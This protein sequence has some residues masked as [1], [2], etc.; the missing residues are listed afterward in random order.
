MGRRALAIACAV[1]AGVFFY[2]ADS[3][4]DG[5]PSEAAPP[6]PDS[7]TPDAGGSGPGGGNDGP[8][9]GV[10]NPDGGT[11]GSGGESDG[12]TGGPDG[13]TSGPDGGTG[14][15]TLPDPN[16]TAADASPG[17]WDFVGSERGGPSRVYGA[18]VDA[19]GNLWVAGGG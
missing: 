4:T 18:A 12:G 16:A 5:T 13:G 1:W 2:C 6:P 11:G 17:G 19:A 3:K 8:D 7:G 15:Y 14:G 10:G 9:A